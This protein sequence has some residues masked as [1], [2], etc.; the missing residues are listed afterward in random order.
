MYRKDR[1]DGRARGSGLASRQTLERRDR[2]TCGPKGRRGAG[3]NQGDRHLPYRQVHAFG[4]GSRGLVSRH[5]GSRRR[6]HRGRSRPRRHRAA[7]RRSCHPPLHARMPPVQV[8]PFGQDQSLHRDPH[9]PGQ[10]RPARWHEPLLHRRQALAALHG[11]LDVCQLHGAARNCSGQGARGRALRQDLLHRLRRDHRHRCGDLHR[12]GRTG[13]QRRRVRP[14]RHRPER[15]A[16]RALGRRRQ[17]CRGRPEPWPRSVGA[18]IRPDP[19]RS[20]RRTTARIWSRT[21]SSSPAA[22]PTT[23]SSASATPR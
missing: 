2:A 10:G 9:D 22:V 6:G 15:R 18:Q 7:Q 23:A 14:G 3:R 17:D 5:P 11:M 16:G 20:L 13:R 1:H 8:L 12:Q 19:L 21:W 4:R